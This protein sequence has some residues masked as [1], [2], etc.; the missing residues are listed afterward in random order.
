VRVTD[1][2]GDQDAAQREINV[3][4][5]QPPVADLQASATAGDKPLEV[6]F[7]ASASADPDGSIVDYEWDFD[8]DGSFNESSN[9]E[10][11]AQGDSAPPAFTYQSSGTFDA[12]VR[13]STRRQHGRRRRRSR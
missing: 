4:D 6:A 5:S 11:L 8:G 3:A 13:V 7:D 1:N 10:D 2:S 12:A 9:G